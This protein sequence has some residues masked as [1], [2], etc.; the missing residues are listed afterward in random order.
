MR[1]RMQMLRL[2][3]R[4]AYH[5]AAAAVMTASS[6]PRADG[7][8]VTERRVHHGAAPR[9]PVGQAPRNAHGGLVVEPGQAAPLP[10][11]GL[12]AVPRVRGV[13]GDPCGSGFL[14]GHQ[15]LAITVVV[16]LASGV[17]AVPA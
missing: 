17:S 6:E 5:P 14:L 8:R 3:G 2:G 10:V 12:T 1:M 13:W 7:G 9:A 16:S 15:V 11:Q 4:G